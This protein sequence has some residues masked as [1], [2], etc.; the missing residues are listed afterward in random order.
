MSLSKTFFEIMP[1]TREFP[2]RALKFFDKLI[3]LDF[4]TLSF[5][6]AAKQYRLLD[7]L[8]DDISYYSEN[9]LFDLSNEE[10]AQIDLF[11]ERF[12]EFKE[13][14]K[15]NILE[16]AD[17]CQRGKESKVYVATFHGGS[18]APRD[19]GFG[20]E[21]TFVVSLH[22][23]CIQQFLD[24]PEG[25]IDFKGPLLY[26]GHNI[27][28]QLVLFEKPRKEEKEIARATLSHTR[29]EIYYMLLNVLSLVNER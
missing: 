10:Q 28:A 24:S 8:A 13:T 6:D 21:R 27:P 7:N 17:N 20:F 26:D 18:L 22:E 12:S 23:N 15:Y 1:E 14:M 25:V 11:L 16:F 29:E 2:A 5:E 9:F 3:E 4:K 19:D